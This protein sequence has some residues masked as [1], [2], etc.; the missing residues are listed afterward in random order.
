M[1]ELLDNI[2]A[3]GDTDKNQFIENGELKMDKILERFVFHFNEIYGQ[4]TE[5]FREEEGRRYFMLYVRPIINGTGN[6]YIEA[7]TRDRSRTDMIIDYLGR[8]YII[9]MKIWRGESYNERGERQL[10]EYLDYY[11]IDKGYLLS[12]CFNRNKQQG[13]KTIKIGNR[14]IVEAV[15]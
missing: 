4:Q 7:E 1:N 9:E 3:A 5:K 10:L 12:F 8:Q 15:V 6:Y 2:Y 14:E 11:H 13:V